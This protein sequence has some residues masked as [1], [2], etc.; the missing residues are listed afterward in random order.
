MIALCKTADTISKSCSC[1]IYPVVGARAI[2]I[3]HGRLGSLLFIT[4][5]GVLTVLKHACADASSEVSRH[6]SR[7]NMREGGREAQ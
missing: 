4:V 3:S 2:G 5:I 7:V 6:R 1:H